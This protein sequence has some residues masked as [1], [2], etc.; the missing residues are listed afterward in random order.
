MKILQINLSN[1]FPIPS[2]AQNA[3]IACESLELLMTCLKLRCSLLNIFYT[4]P[5]V[6]EFVIDILLGC[7]HPDVRLAMATQLNQLCQEI[8][9]GK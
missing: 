6:G 5:R 8:D 2:L 3:A 9:T 7:P 4:L 1:I